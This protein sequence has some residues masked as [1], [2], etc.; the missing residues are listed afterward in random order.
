VCEPTIAAVD[1]A[2]GRLVAF[3]TEAARM[4]GRAAGRIALVR[5]MRHGQLLDLT[6]TDSILSHLLRRAGASWRRRP[7]VVACIPGGATGV[8]RRA[9]ERGVRHAGA[10]RV[11]LLDH[12]TAC[13]IGARLPIEDAAGSMIV[14]IGGGTTEIGILALGAT[15]AFATVPIGGGDLDESIRDHCRRELDLIVDR[16]TAEQV[17]QAIGSTTSAGDEAKA[18]VR[19]RDAGDGSERTVVLSSTELYDVMDARIREIV[20]KLVAAIQHA[21]PDLA[22]DLLHRGIHL[23]GGCARQTGLPERI[24][25]ETGLPVHV[26]A[27]PER[28]ALQGA[29]RCIILGRR[30]SGQPAAARRA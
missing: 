13:A 15:A 29:L 17:R 11:Q 20:A 2:D 3:G 7:L 28:C 23:A 1:L 12:Q 9:L 10:S 30:Q 4:R 14:D 5:P 18:E 25:A 16:W 27:S 6:L 21:P 24:R 26:V 22:N 8:Q 19:G